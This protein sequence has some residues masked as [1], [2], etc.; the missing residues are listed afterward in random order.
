M[1]QVPKLM[2]IL[3]LP[4]KS[5]SHFLFENEFENKFLTK[6]FVFFKTLSCELI[7]ESQQ[8][9]PANPIYIKD[10]LKS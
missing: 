3:N 2:N 5:F 8:H 10:L 9:F 1:I 4:T 7:N 6:V